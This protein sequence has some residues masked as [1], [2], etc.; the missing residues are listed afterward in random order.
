M[1][2]GSPSHLLATT[3]WHT[4]L[5]RTQHNSACPLNTA[6]ALY[7][8]LHAAFF[9]CFEITKSSLCM[10]AARLA[11]GDSLAFQIAESAH[12]GGADHTNAAQDTMGK[13]R[14]FHVHFASKPSTCKGKNGAVVSFDTPAKS[15]LVMRNFKQLIRSLSTTVAAV[16][17]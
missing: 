8:S 15:R 14:L 9:F 12:C 10:N 17:R 5:C 16:T 2:A 13:L 1:L 4:F 3:S 11:H 7:C 6:R